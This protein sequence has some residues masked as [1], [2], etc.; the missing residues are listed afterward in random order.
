MSIVFPTAAQAAQRIVSAIGAPRRDATVDEFL[1]GDPN[2]AVTGIVTTMIASSR[3]LQQAAD[4][5]A[6]LVITHEPLF[7]DHRDE[8]RPDLIREAD[9]VYREKLSCLEQHGVVVWHLH[10]ALHDLRP[11]LVDV[12]TARRLGWTVPETVGYPTV[13]DIA[14]QTL[15][16]LA[17]TVADQLGAPATRFIG[18]GGMTCS[19]VGFALGFRGATYIRHLLARPDIQVVIA[20]EIHEWE[21]G[22]YVDDAVTLGFPKA[23]LVVGHIP[24]EQ[25]GMREIADIA[26]H[27]LP[28]LPVSFIACPDVYAG[29]IR[30]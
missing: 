22:G 20:G 24:S 5:H 12:G 13:L 30:R 6:N 14:P 1:Y 7:W 23:L 28:G 3:V 21:I 10:D 25:Y 15:A 4:S 17:T 18:A 29:G 2:A 9:P 27:A 26:S 19:R 16:E 8:A 11:D